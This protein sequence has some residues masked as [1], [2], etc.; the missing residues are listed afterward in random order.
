MHYQLKCPKCMS[1]YHILD[2]KDKFHICPKCD[3]YYMKSDLIIENQH[4]YNS[5]TDYINNYIKICE[6]FNSIANLNKLKAEKE[7][8]LTG[9]NKFMIVNTF[10]NNNKEF[11]KLKNII[12]DN[13]K[14]T[15]SLELYITVL[16]DNFY[17]DKKTLNFDKM[18]E[19]KQLCELLKLENKNV[20]KLNTIV[21][22]IKTNLN[23]KLIFA[24]IKY[25]SNV[26][27]KIID[28]INS[29]YIYN[30]K[31]EFILCDNNIYKIMYVSNDNKSNSI[32]LSLKRNDDKFKIL[33]E[34]I[35]NKNNIEILELIKDE[36]EIWDF[37]DK[38]IIL[39]KKENELP[40]ELLS[41]EKDYECINI[42]YTNIYTN[43]S[44]RMISSVLFKSKDVENVYMYVN[45]K[46]SFLVYS[47]DINKDNVFGSSSIITTDTNIKLKLN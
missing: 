27:E 31:V 23:W 5:I 4:L 11:I 17:F 39:D 24:D 42:A 12:Y 41:Y 40:K 6:V 33:F 36:L 34:N 15:S 37:I 26:L 22:K 19:F 47:V 18:L 25:G 8:I 1:I 13:N 30:G 3:S 29:I 32:L 45:F 38:N 9:L 35:Y 14:E 7:L 10:I 21:I 43:T 28:R 20:I 44:E 46:G 16:N 2:I